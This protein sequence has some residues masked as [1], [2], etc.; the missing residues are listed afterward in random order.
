MSVTP[1]FA[2]T[3]ER[4]LAQR[5]AALA[6]AASVEINVQDVK[7]LDASRAL[8]R[9]GR[10]IFV[11]HLPKQAWDDTVQACRAVRQAEFEPIPHIPV[12]LLANR[13][14]YDDL[15]AALVREAGVR[16]V[17]LISGDYPQAQGEY[18]NVLQALR[19]DLLQ[20]HGIT[21][22][23]LAG[24]PEGHPRVALEEIRQAE[25]DK[26]RYA[27]QAGLQATFVTQFCF[28]PEPFLVWSRELDEAGVTAPRVAGL[29]GPAKL[30]TLVN[31]A[32]RCGV[33]RSVRALSSRPGVL[34]QLMSEQKPDDILATLAQAI[35]ADET[36]I[37]GL[38]MFCFGGF[39]R[40]CKWLK[41]VA[42]R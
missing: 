26:A 5:T 38:H 2:M 33:G 39:L 8:L 42:D 27:H 35:Q 13:A 24:H 17:L 15:L 14:A 19:T 10:K 23:N 20:R 3:P 18:S 32:L 11:A 34:T 28:E 22:V 4:L 40:T 7:H 30:T 29:A 36:K 6:S 41:E 31:F 12:R 37:S 1:L 21:R 9:A 16:E 25:I